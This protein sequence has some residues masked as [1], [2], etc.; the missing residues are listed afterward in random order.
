MTLIVLAVAVLIVM[1]VCAPLYTLLVGIT[2]VFLAFAPGVFVGDHESYFPVWLKFWEWTG[3]I[4]ILVGYVWI[5]TKAIR[6]RARRRHGPEIGMW[7]PGAHATK[8]KEDAVRRSAQL[9][10][11]CHPFP[12]QL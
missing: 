3:F 7:K 8:L 12:P 1:L 9:E 5:I 10:L 4:Y 11:N 2:L 6:S